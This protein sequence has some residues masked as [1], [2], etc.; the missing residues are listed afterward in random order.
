MTSHLAPLLRRFA[1]AVLVTMAAACSAPTP[2]GPYSPNDPAQRDATRAEQLTREAVD[3]AD[4]DPAHAESLLREALT[5]DLYHGPAHN[6]LGVLYFRDGRLYEAANEFEWARK[7]LPGHPDPRLNLALVLERAGHVAEAFTAYDSALEAAP[8]HVPT[9]QAYARLAVR[10]GRRDERI[11][12]MLK[13]IALRGED[14]S[15]RAWA[16]HAELTMPGGDA[17]KGR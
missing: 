17:A 15:W 6:N 8:E 10:D 9:M 14:E 1:A 7:L 12:S 3:C 13:T 11:T 5:A 4:E 16:Q 2:T